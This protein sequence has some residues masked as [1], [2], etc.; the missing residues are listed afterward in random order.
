MFFSKERRASVVAE[1]P[2][3]AFG[4]VGKKI[5]EAWKALPAE[6]RAPFEAQAAAD[7]ER[8]IREDRAYKANKTAAAGDDAEPASDGD[9]DEADMEE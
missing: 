2:G 6:E 3:I 9:G 1:N 5:G 7:K 4:E 8:F